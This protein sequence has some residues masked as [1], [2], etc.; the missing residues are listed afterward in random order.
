MLS[1]KNFKKKLRKIWL[2]ENYDIY[3]KKLGQEDNFQRKFVFREVKE[4]KDISLVAQQFKG[5]FGQNGAKVLLQRINNGKILIAGF[6][7]KESDKI[8]FISWLSDSEPAF[9][10]IMKKKKLSKKIL[11]SFRTL[12]PEEFRNKKVGREGIS[13]AHELAVKKGFEEILCIVKKD[14]IASK[15]MLESLGW[16]KDGDFIRK[17]LFKKETFK[18]F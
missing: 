9:L 11:Y 4:E 14:N 17:V 7:T 13:Y 6:E 1:I 16:S 18:V 10:E 2:V 15:K 8:C 3:E 5:H 12:V